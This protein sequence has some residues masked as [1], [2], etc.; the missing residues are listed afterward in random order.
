MIHPSPERIKYL[1]NVRKFCLKILFYSRA[2]YNELRNFFSNRLPAQRTL[3]RWLRCVDGSPGITQLA[4]DTLSEKVKEYKDIN[5]KLHLCIIHDEMSIKKQV[6]WND[7]TKSFDGFRTS[8]NQNSNDEKLPVAKDALVYMVTGPDFRIA[9]AYF[10]LAGL[11][12]VDR[13]ALTGEVIRN[14]EATGAIVMSLTGDGLKA[15]I[16]SY[17]ILGADFKVEKPFFLSPTDANRKIYFIFDPPHMLKLVRKDFAVHKLYFKNE[18]LRWDLLETLAEKQDADNFELANKLT[19]RRHVS[20]K[21]SPMTVRY[22]VETMSNSVA[23]VL[24]QLCEDKYMDFVGCEATV[25]F[26][27]LI[28]NLFDVMNHG[29]G[30]K[31]D[32]RYKQPICETTITKFQELFEEFKSFVDEMSIVKISKKGISQ[33]TKLTSYL[34]EQPNKFV[35]FF[36][37][38]QNISSTIGIYNDYVKNGLLDVFYPFQYSQDQLETYFS[39]VRGSCGANTNPNV[40]QFMAAYRKLLLCI[41]HMSS[42]YTNCNYFE[43]SNILTVSSTQTPTMPS[44]NDINSAE[45]IEINTDYKMLLS[46]ERDPYEHHMCAYISSTIEVNIVQKIKSHC[47]SACQDCLSVF[48]ENRKINDSFIEKKNKS[49]CPLIQPCCST[50]DILI[51]CNNVCKILEENYSHV[52][53]NIVCKTIWNSINIDELYESSQFNCHH[54]ADKLPGTLT[55]KEHFVIAVV[56]EYMRMKSINICKRIT[57][58]E[59]AESMKRRKVRRI[60]ILTGR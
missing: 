26:I 51:I 12:S 13:A 9:V 60:N 25:K 30:K 52:N 43:V 54:H 47:I 55:H 22:A 56:Q 31:S 17:H 2:A 28:N 46:P 48:S 34:K 35:G 53:Y 50:R 19:K 3:Q 20:W 42:K 24:E 57:D 38:L 41:P 15:N 14:I 49:G 23:D 59:W 5:K 4:L 37:F 7:E 8:K 36:G 44:C 27:R 10:L 29:D 40:V 16:A 6:L 18:L 32:D 45:A 11:D 1:P 21:L 58:E 33:K 39:L